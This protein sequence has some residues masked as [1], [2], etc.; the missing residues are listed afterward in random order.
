VCKAKDLPSGGPDLIVQPLY[1]HPAS[2]DKSGHWAAQSPGLADQY[3]QEAANRLEEHAIT[4]NKN[5]IPNDPRSFVETSGIRI[6][7]AAETTRGMKRDDFAG[8][9]ERIADILSN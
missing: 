1:T 6:G 2:S 5:G 4:V 8:I 7:T 3:R 9:A